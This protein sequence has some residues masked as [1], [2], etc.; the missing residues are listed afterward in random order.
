MVTYSVTGSATSNASSITYQT[1]EGGGARG[2]KMQEIDASL[3]W[4]RTV[5][6]S[7]LNAPLFVRVENRSVGLFSV[8]CSIS[9]DGTVLSSSRAEGSNAVASC[10]TRPAGRD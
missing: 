5:V 6:T 8:T 3:P 10:G 1:P 9:E 2:G 7:G 4:T